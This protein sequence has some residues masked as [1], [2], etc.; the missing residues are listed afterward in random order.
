MVLI[1]YAYPIFIA[2]VHKKG[3]KTRP[4]IGMS[5]MASYMLQS[6]AYYRFRIVGWPHRL[7]WPQSAGAADAIRFSSD[8]APSK[9]VESWFA[10]RLLDAMYVGSGEGSDKILLHFEK[11][12]GSCRC[13]IHSLPLSQ[14]MVGG[15][16]MRAFKD[17]GSWA[18][19]V[20][21]SHG[22]T[23]LTVRDGYLQLNKV[24]VPINC[25]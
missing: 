9:T 12:S 24:T 20:V 19:L 1:E 10:F 3:E 16:D 15:L 23:L 13:L 2:T 22:K 5:A 6:S 4:A 17:R 25:V 21:D 7:H 11:V 8:M 18:A 14:L